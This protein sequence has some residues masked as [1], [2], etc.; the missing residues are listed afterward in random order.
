MN[1]RASWSRTLARPTF[2]ELAPVAT[3]EFLF[4]DEFLGNPKLRLSRIQ[5]YDLRWEWFRRAGEVLAASVFYKDIV[6]PI[7]QISFAAG[8]RFF[9]QP[10]N[11]DRGN[12]RGLE[13]EARSEL[14][15][16][17]DSLRGLA[18]TVNY[19][20][21]ESQVEVPLAERVSL[22]DYSLDQ[23][24]RRLQGQPDSIINASLVYEND[25]YGTSAGLFY[26]RVGETL[27]TGAARG[28]NGGIPNVIELPTSSLDL[29]ISQKLWQHFSVG[30]KA[31]NLLRPDRRSVYRTPGGDEAPRVQ[32]ETA[33]LFGLSATVR[34]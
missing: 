7:E 5:N 12:V 31:R 28:L 14:D 18:A 25:Y 16:F 19:T 34:W 11:Y 33:R 21:I 15:V 6:D 20:W 9:I 3:E 2:R 10:I 4:G 22:S 13:V 26:N 8:G 32:R 23:T 30:F 29:T 17:A 27:Q 1:V 24:Q